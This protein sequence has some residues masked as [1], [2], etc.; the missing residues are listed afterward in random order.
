MHRDSLHYASELS[1]LNEEKV[2]HS[3]SAGLQPEQILIIIADAVG[4]TG[5]SWTKKG[6]S[7]DSRLP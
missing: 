1:L 7:G 3:H 4:G 6:I 5:P 2:G